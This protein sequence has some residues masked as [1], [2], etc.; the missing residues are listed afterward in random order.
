M[1]KTLSTDLI[2]RE[3]AVRETPTV[4]WWRPLPD[5]PEK[6]KEER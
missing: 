6:K 2:S 5:P 4:T 1:D 3:A